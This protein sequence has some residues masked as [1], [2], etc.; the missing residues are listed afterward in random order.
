[1]NIVDI[2]KVLNKDKDRCILIGRNALNFL[3]IHDGKGAAY[4]TAD[5]DLAC[6]SIE[7]AEECGEILRC[8]G[9]TKHNTTYCNSNGGEI[10]IVLAMSDVPEGVV[11]GEYYN[12]PS[13]YSLWE[14]RENIDGVLVP[15]SAEIIYNKLMHVRENEGKDIETVQ[16]YLKMSKG[17]F[18]ALLSRILNDTKTSKEDK[19]NMLYSLYFAVSG[20]KNDDI[21]Q[22]VEHQLIHLKEIN[23]NSSCFER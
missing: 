6:V 5:Y 18:E 8:H 10:D 19:E 11:R 13:L 14:A 17:L 2:L 1:M 21:K 7:A 23:G 20:I 3:N 15:S 12:I 4:H 9:F 16:I 22:K